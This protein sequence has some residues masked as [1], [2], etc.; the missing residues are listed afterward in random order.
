MKK[1]ILIIIL[2]ILALMTL[3]SYNACT[4]SAAQMQ[5]TEMAQDSITS[6]NY[7]IDSMQVTE[8]KQDTVLY[9][10]SSTTQDTIKKMIILRKEIKDVKVDTTVKIKKDTTYSKLEK[11]QSILVQ[12]QKT[13]DSLIIKKKKH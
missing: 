1:R 11:T 4:S 9:T 5:K 7:I 6:L 3:V 12:Q 2:A 13:I 8:N 10:F